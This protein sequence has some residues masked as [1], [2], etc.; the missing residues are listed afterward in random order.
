VRQLAQRLIAETQCIVRHPRHIHIART[1]AKTV[2]HFAQ[3][4][5]DRIAGAFRVAWRLAPH[6]RR[7]THH[8]R[9]PGFKVA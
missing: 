3:R 6:A 9:E 1:T 4:A 5:D 7:S 8:A 2:S